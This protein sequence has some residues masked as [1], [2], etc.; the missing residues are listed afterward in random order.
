MPTLYSL[1]PCTIEFYSQTVS[2]NSKHVE[3]TQVIKILHLSLQAVKRNFKAHNIQFYFATFNI[4]LSW[5][6]QSQSHI[7]SEKLKTSAYIWLKV[8]AALFTLHLVMN[9]ISIQTSQLDTTVISSPTRWWPHSGSD[10]MNHEA[11]G[12]RHE[13]YLLL[14]LTTSV[15]CLLFGPQL[16]HRSSTTTMKLCLSLMIVSLSA[17]VCKFWKGLKRLLFGSKL[18]TYFS[19]IS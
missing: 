18:L 16:G 4:S 9:G 2:K 15:S 5:N 13:P 17:L 3:N 19:T 12:L 7:M 6:F 11:A 1:A 10:T 14:L 8:F